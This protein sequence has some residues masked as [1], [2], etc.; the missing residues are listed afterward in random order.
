ME[1]KLDV[2]VVGG[3]LSGLVT[4]AYLGRA[5]LGTVVV[6][7][8][9]E[10]GG[11]ARTTVE[12]GYSLNL[13]A[14]AVYRNGPAW[15]VLGELGVPLEGGIPKA[16]GALAL[17]NGGAHALPTGLLSLVTTGLLGLGGKL[18]LSRVLATLG[19][20]DTAPLVRVPAMEWIERAATAPEARA[21][22]CALFRVATYTGDLH[23]LSAGAALSQVQHVAKHNVL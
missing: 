19:G 3:G 20:I 18:E 12:G 22:L 4:A 15:S 23:G 13:G 8:A 10:L 17:T 7:K 1:E 9:R 5:G 16:T 11:R 6:E 14:H 2:V 21:F